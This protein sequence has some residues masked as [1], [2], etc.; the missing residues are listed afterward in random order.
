MSTLKDVFLTNT[1]LKE[2]DYSEELETTQHIVPG[3]DKLRMALDRMDR[4]NRLNQ[5]L[6]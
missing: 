6:D 2:F 1:T 3:L 4:L 5:T